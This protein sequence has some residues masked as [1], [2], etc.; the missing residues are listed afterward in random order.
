MC[1]MSRIGRD[2]LFFS[3]IGHSMRAAFRLI[4]GAR[5]LAKDA[6]NLKSALAPEIGGAFP[7]AGK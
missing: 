3:M 7:A 4:R 5:G 6:K 2:A 1:P